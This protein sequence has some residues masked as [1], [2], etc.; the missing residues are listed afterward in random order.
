[1]ETQIGKRTKEYRD[2]VDV[3]PESPAKDFDHCPGCGAKLLE[4]EKSS[5]CEAHCKKCIWEEV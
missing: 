3:P 5:R 1:M 4:D 2:S